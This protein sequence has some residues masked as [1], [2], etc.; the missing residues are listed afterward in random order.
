MLQD[1]ALVEA[2]ITFYEHSLKYCQGNV[3]TSGEVHLSTLF[4]AT[5]ET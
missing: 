5:K 3:I 2:I 1:R 4:L